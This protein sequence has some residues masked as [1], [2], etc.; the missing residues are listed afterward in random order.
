MICYCNANKLGK[1]IS[2]SNETMN[3]CLGKNYIA[4]DIFVFFNQ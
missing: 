4:Y 1:C 3:K 2:L